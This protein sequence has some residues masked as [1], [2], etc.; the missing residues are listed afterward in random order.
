VPASTSTMKVSS[1]LEGIDFLAVD[2]N[3]I[4]ASF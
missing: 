4:A 3:F 2:E 1:D